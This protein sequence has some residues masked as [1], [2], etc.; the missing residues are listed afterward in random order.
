MGDTFTS[1]PKKEKTQSPAKATTLSVPLSRSKSTL[2][3]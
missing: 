3:A 1:W 2:L